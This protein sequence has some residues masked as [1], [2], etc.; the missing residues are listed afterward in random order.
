MR[1]IESGV[2]LMATQGYHRTSIQQIAEAAGISKGAFYLYFDSKEAFVAT[3][4]E[5]FH[6]RIRQR[7]ETIQKQNLS[8]KQSLAQEIN[9]MTESIYQYKNFIIMHIREKV[10]IGKHTNHLIQ[11][12]N[13][14]NFRWLRDHIKTI[15]GERVNDYLLD[16]IIQFEGL[17]SG[18]FKSIV[19]DHVNINI[20]HMGP[21]LVERLD[22]LVNG[23]INKNDTP[24][25]SSI[26]RTKLDLM[27]EDGTKDQ[28]TYDMLF[29][30]KE[31]IDILSLDQKKKDE[32]HDVVNTVLRKVSEETMQTV[33]IQGL[34][35]H[36][37]RIPEL[38]A[39]CEQFAEI[40]QIDLI[41]LHK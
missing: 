34:L 11:E 16:C 41:D 33:V 15:Y 14:Y 27:L 13:W 32:L 30:M 29:R 19:I 28:K 6:T 20:D 36:L 21:F 4:F 25:M 35:V 31:K 1:L 7:I 37:Q 26:Y 2:K 9:V 23:M 38:M 10:S 8:P 24:L 12:I 40:I 17:M 5:Y 39:L 22:D 3:A 18:Y